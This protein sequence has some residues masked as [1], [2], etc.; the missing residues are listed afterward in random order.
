MLLIWLPT[1]MLRQYRI[2]ICIHACFITFLL[3][4]KPRL[5]QVTKH[6]CFYNKLSVNEIKYE[7]VDD[8]K[9]MLQHTAVLTNLP[10]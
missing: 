1:S 5:D 4:N 7:T 10:K 3:R 8:K 9:L 2:V 6:D